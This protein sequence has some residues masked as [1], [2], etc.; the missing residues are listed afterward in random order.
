MVRKLDGVPLAP[1]LIAQLQ[2]EGHPEAPEIWPRLG[3]P[4]GRTGFLPLE[5]KRAL[6]AAY[7]EFELV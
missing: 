5:A 6:I 3:V 2:A 7:E 1:L 4:R